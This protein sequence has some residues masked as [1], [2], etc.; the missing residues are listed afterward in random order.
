MP[1]TTQGED[2]DWTRTRAASPDEMQAGNLDEVRQWPNNKQAGTKLGRDD[3]RVCGV[4]HGVC[5]ML[6]CDRGLAPRVHGSN[7][8]QQVSCA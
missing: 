8:V 4:A 2:A 5:G 1:K 6:G 7:V 3:V